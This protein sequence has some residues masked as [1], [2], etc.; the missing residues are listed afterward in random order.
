[1]ERR[2]KLAKDSSWGIDYVTTL[3]ET[4]PATLEKAMIYSDNIYFAKVALK[5]GGR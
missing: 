1:M 3:H 4:E 5:L 2:V